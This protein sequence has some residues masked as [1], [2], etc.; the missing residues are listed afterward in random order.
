MSQDISVRVRV[1]LPNRPTYFQK[2]NITKKISEHLLRNFIYI[3]RLK[4]V[5]SFD[6]GGFLW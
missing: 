6:G 4:K 3:Y 5:V 2:K 1:A